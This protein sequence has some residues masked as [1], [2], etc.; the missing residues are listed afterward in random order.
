MVPT[1]WIIVTRASIS[2]RGFDEGCES[3]ELTY[4]EMGTRCL[5]I[6]FSQIYPAQGE[7]WPPV[8]TDAHAKS[9]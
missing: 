2:G 8:L 6:W 1:L 4:M 9:V 5:R 7:H 3:C